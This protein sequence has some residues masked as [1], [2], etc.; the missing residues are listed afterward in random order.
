MLES[1]NQCKG[2]IGQ[3]V[4]YKAIAWLLLQGYEVFKNVTYHGPVDLIALDPET[5]AIKLV[6]V[7]KVVD[8]SRK[9]TKV[10][11][12]KI[13]DVQRSLGVAPLFYDE[14]NNFFAWT[15]KEIYDRLGKE[16]KSPVVVQPQIV[17]GHE[18][19][20]FAEMCRH[21]EVHPPSLRTWRT[22]NPE[23]SI[24]EAISWAQTHR[25]IVHVNGQTYSNKREACKALGIE[26]RTVEYWTYD[27]G[28]TFEAAVNAILLKKEK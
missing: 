21:F 2:K 14:K 8:G 11:H 20:S 12:P 7:K 5:K 28:L 25:K 24:E 13:S 4:E 3:V 1:N 15:T 27:K 18:F 10:S 6:D 22:Q 19:S 9:T 17:L 26:L 16:K 23:A